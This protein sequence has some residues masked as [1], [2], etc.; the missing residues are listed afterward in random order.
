M[1]LMS[2]PLFTNA[3]PVECRSICGWISKCS[4]PAALAISPIMCQTVT[5]ESGFRRSPDKERVDV[6]RR[7]HLRPLNQPRL[8]RLALAVVELVWSRV[9]TFEPVHVKLFPGQLRKRKFTY[10]YDAKGAL[11]RRAERSTQEIE[12]FWHS[13]AVSVRNSQH[14]TIRE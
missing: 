7:I 8:H 13:G 11:H 4:R 14:S 3:Y 9:A 12:S 2:V 6:S 1:I 5:R 10:A